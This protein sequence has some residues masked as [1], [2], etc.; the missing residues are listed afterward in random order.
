MGHFKEYTTMHY[1]EIEIHTQTKN[2]AE[3][4]MIGNWSVI[5]R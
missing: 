4:W 5:I 3:D 2:N 1:F